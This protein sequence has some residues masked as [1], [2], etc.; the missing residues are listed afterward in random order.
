MENEEI[1]KAIRERLKSEHGDIVRV[2]SQN[3]PKWFGDGWLVSYEVPK[4]PSE[5]TPIIR[6]TFFRNED[7]KPVLAKEIIVRDGYG[8]YAE[9]LWTPRAMIQPR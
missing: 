8:N 2:H 6:A 9:T 3:A 5:K 1:H 4:R 7:G